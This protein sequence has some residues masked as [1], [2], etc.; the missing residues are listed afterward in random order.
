MT[1]DELR[2]HKYTHT[3]YKLSALNIKYYKFSSNFDT[4]F[5]SEIV[6]SCL[7]GV[8]RQSNLKLT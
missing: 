7:E 1:L 5:Y 3:D 6:E 4:E 2:I 8:N